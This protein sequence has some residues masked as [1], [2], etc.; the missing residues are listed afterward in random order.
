MGFK[1]LKK[2]PIGSSKIQFIYLLVTL[3][4]LFSSWT[5]VFRLSIFIQ[6]PGALFSC[7]CHKKYFQ[8]R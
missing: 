5:F 2:I 3:I 4:S 1:N 6:F 7:C 8:I